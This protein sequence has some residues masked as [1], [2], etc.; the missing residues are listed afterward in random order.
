MNAPDL[1][2]LEELF[3]AA[4]DLPAAERPAFFDRECPEAPELRRRLGEES[5]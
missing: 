5:Q 3:Q 1:K 2:R 4:A